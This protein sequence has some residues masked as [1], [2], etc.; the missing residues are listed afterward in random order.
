MAASFAAVALILAKELRILPKKLPTPKLLTSGFSLSSE[1]PRSTE[2]A[3]LSETTRVR[4]AFEI[5]FVP[6]SF[7]RASLIFKIIFL[8]VDTTVLAVLRFW[9]RCSS[10]LSLWLWPPL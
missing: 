8:T 3:L 10:L 1:P 2:D 4:R 5:G 6:C 7:L 9:R